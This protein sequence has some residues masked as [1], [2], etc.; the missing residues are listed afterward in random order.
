MGLSIYFNL[1]KDFNQF[2]VTIY[3]RGLVCLKRDENK[4]HKYRIYFEKAWTSKN[5]PKKS[6]AVFADISWETHIVMN[7]VKKKLAL[8]KYNDAIRGN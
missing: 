1:H 8:L 3:L 7:V 6:T 2:T 5:V 4:Y